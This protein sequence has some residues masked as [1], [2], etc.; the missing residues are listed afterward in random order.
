MKKPAINYS[1]PVILSDFSQDSVNENF[2]RAKLWVYY[3]GETPDKRFFSDSFAEQ[4]IST[5][6]YTPVVSYYDEEKEDFIG[7]ASQQQIYGIV[8][9][10]VAPVF[11]TR[12]EDGKEWC[13]AEVVLYTERPDKTGEI[14]K[15][16]VGQPHSLELNPKTVKY[17]INYDEKKHFK[18]IEFTAGDFVGVSVLGKDQKPAFT[19]SAFFEASEEF[20]NKM[21]LLHEYCEHAAN[22]PQTN[23]GESMNLEEFMK[24]S[25]GDISAKVDRA[26]SKEYENDAYT[27]IV[28]MFE[29][30]AI[31]RFYYYIG[32]DVKLMRVHY[33][34]DENGE[35]AL[36]TVNEVRITY[37]DVIESPSAEINM[38]QVEEV[39]EPQITDAVSDCEID[40]IDTV[41]TTN[42][43]VTEVL[44]EPVVN[45]EE[46]SGEFAGDKTEEDEEEDKETKEDEDEEVEEPK[47]DEDEEEKFVETIVE[48][49]PSVEDFVEETTSEPAQVT[50]VEITPTTETKVSVDDEQNSTIQETSSSSTSFTESERAEFEALKRKEKI[51]LIDSYKDNLTDDEYAQFTEQVD[52]FTKDTLELELLKAYKRNVDAE[53]TSSKPMRA[54]ALSSL[55]NN[56]NKQ[57]STLDTFVR[58]YKR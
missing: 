42:A 30:S 36:G 54:F 43:E 40:Q 44:E 37:E 28:D 1:W 12:E 41:E 35:I 10:C 57:E 32:G 2:S 47:K 6:P 38:K 24:L 9:P 11:T 18:N 48:E 14:A 5:L 45:P 15:K 8:D 17:V 27:Y 22:D 56:A 53:S 21:R 23:G 16:I 3:K 58:K 55:N 52:S 29:D 39:E 20:E 33:S 34:C 46:N 31:A 51:D 13:V 26:I 49:T 19:G 4:I 7:H 50:D 25:W